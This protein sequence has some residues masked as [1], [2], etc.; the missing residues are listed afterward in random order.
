MEVK[1]FELV[2][3][4]AGA[5]VPKYEFRD[6]GEFSEII[7]KPV[8][9]FTG[10]DNRVLSKKIMHFAQ[11]K[12]LEFLNSRLE[13]Y[14]SSVYSPEY[15]MELKSKEKNIKLN[16]EKADVEF[17]CPEE[18]LNLI[19]KVKKL[20]STEY[21]TWNINKINEDLTKIYNQF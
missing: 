13:A 15:H 9:K 2:K 8:I 17:I 11:E 12:C 14:K 19:D 7:K 5:L 18:A 4:E 21:M 6:F 16:I 20:P 10:Y 3:E 1:L